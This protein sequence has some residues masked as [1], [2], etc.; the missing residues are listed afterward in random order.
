MAAYERNPDGFADGDMKIP[1]AGNGLPDLLDEVKWELDFLLKMQVPGGK[2]M[3]GM[4][5][6][7]VHDSEWTGLPL[8]PDKDDKKRELHRPSTAAT[9]NMAAAAAQGARL[10][11]G[12]DDAYSA[13]LLAAAKSAFAAAKANPAVFATPE[14]GASGGGPYD[15][16]EVAD[17]FYWAATEL[18][19][20]TGEQIYLDEVDTIKVPDEMFFP[21]NGAFDWKNVATFALLEL[22]TVD[23]D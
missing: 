12:K 7:K 18:Y 9:L 10:F 11:K 17:E 16:T 13:T 15:D 22:L 4:V 5:F 3:A 20:T 14:D 21:M 1:E 23:S 2:P 19:L 8:M 6:H